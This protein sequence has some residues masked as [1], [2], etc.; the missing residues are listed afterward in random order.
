[1]PPHLISNPDRIHR[2][3]A[4]VHRWIAGLL[5]RRLAAFV[6]LLAFLAAGCVA[7]I[8]ADRVNTRRAY[9]QVEA[10]A[11]RTGR[12]SAETVSLLHQYDLVRLA[13][14]H[15][16][17]AV[18]QLHQAAV[19]SGRRDLLFALAELSYVAG[20]DIRRSV[21]PWDPRD[22]RDYYLG[23]A[24]YAW[25]YL[26]GDGT[27]SSQNPFDRRFREACDFYNR[28]LGLAFTERRGTNAVAVVEGGRRPLPV[29]ALT[30]TYSEPDPTIRRSDFEKFL[31]A[32]LFEVRGLSVRIR[33]AGLGAPLIAVRPISTE[34][35]MRGSA[36]VTAFLNIRSSLAG[37]TNGQ[38]DARLALY[39]AWNGSTVTVGNR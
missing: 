26:F 5:D 9:D 19:D 33:G 15:P 20:E 34:F 2:C 38:A 10:N 23:S 13:E 16:D 35:G 17:E 3:A 32:D 14:R 7:P 27:E 25:L 36:P 18:R 22:A 24:V 31:L 37:L 11:L 21:K 1:M 8:G 39:S 29:G 6:P 30:I 12:P 28:S 4:I